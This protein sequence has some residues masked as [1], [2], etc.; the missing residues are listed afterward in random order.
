MNVYI[1]MRPQEFKKII[2]GIAFIIGVN[3]GMIILLIILL[4]IKF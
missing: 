3:V 4:T 1:D 2:N